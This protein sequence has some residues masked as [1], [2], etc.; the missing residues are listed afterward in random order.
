MLHKDEWLST[1]FKA[2]AYAYKPPFN[3]AVLPDGFIYAKVQTNNIEDVQEASRQGFCV[4][5]VLVQFQQQR[6]VEQKIT[7]YAL[8]FSKAEDRDEVVHIARDAFIESRLYKDPAIP[9]DVAAHIKAHW[10]D[11]FYNGAR[12]DNMIVAEENGRIIGFVLLIGQV[13]DLIAVAPQDTKKG[14]ASAMISFANDQIGLLSAGTQLVNQPSIALYQKCGFMLT[15]SAYVLHRHGQKIRGTSMTQALFT[16]ALEGNQDV[17]EAYKTS[18]QDVKWDEIQDKNGNVLIAVA[19]SKGKLHIIQYLVREGATLNIPNKDGRADL[20]I[21][22]ED[23]HPNTAR[24]LIT[25]YEAA[26]LGLTLSQDALQV[27][28]A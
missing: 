28:V 6:F 14:V 19:A 23:G 15:S 3:E 9:N 1:Y 12:G 17:F 26:G 22:Y 16:A 2:G 25:L 20:Q 18:V 21:A 5:E 8:R 24:G 11:N 27:L 10:V 4:V 7:P 13:I